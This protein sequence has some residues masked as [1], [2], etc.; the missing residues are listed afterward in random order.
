[1]LEAAGKVATRFRRDILGDKIRELAERRLVGL[2]D[3][4]EM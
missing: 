2:V 1:M 3:E 4:D